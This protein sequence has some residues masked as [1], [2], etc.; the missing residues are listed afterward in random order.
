MSKLLVAGALERVAYD[1]PEGP[2]RD[3]YTIGCTEPLTFEETQDYLR[4]V[5]L[6]VVKDLRGET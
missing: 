1:L 5:M 4:A 3:G 2:D 6:E